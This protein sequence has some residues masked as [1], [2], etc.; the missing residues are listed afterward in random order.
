MGKDIVNKLLRI[1][2]VILAAL[3]LAP[4]ASAQ[5]ED[6]KLIEP[7]LKKVKVAFY[8]TTPHRITFNIVGTGAEGKKAEIGAVHSR[9]PLF[10][11]FSRTYDT[12]SGVTWEI[13]DGKK[14]PVAQ[15]VV[16]EAARQEVDIKQLISWQRPVKIN[17][18]NNTGAPVDIY[19]TAPDGEQKLIVDD[20]PPGSELKD[21]AV[22]SRPG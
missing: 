14:K 5:E 19:Y 3:A 10:R 22:N 21:A 11:G 1:P 9:K 2:F 8:N 4:V 20:M 16:T 15:Y 17:F 13:L 7:K 6:V 18:Q 12:R